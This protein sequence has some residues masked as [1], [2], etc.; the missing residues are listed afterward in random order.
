MDL[1]LDLGLWRRGLGSCLFRGRGGRRMLGL[2]LGGFDDLLL[3]IRGAR[4]LLTS[5]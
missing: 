5:C 1:K 3:R 4:L 2:R